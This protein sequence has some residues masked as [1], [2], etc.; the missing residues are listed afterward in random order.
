MKK[1]DSVLDLVFPSF[2]KR[3]RIG[4]KEMVWRTCLARPFYL[5]DLT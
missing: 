4:D 3:H 2:E 1:V 5:P